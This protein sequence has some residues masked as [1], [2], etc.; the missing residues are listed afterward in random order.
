MID[1][2]SE[3]PVDEFIRVDRSTSK[4]A[5]SALA[6]EIRIDTLLS[7]MNQPDET[8]TFSELRKAVD[9]DD[10]GKFN[11]HLGK[12]V[13]HF[14][15]KT[16]DGYKLTH[17]GKEIVGAIYGGTYEADAT[18][19][20]LPLGDICITCGGSLYLEYAQ[21]AARIRCEDCDR[22]SDDYPFP[23]RGLDQ[24]SKAEL[25]DTIGKWIDHYIH[26]LLAG[27]CPYCTGRIESQ[28][29]VDEAERL[30][31]FPAH[32]EFTCMR[33]N[34]SHRTPATSP[35]DAHPS[36]RHFLQR[37]GLD[38]HTPVWR[39]FEVMG[40]PEVALLS[41]DPPRL[42]VRISYEEE[43]L[44]AVVDATAKVVQIGWDTVP[45]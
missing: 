33:C 38:V 32:A 34:I 39:I 1:S 26:G 8:Y 24:F 6:N 43:E 42:E 9:V 27:F 17:A 11:Y 7:M 35:V 37:H 15:R 12:L 28:L 40:R 2:T 41:K 10:P 44:H 16:D 18:V 21:E 29:C 31:G 3:P 22:R 14:I 45:E 19:E 30:A 4:E 25:R 20:Y 5:W 13:D 36:F 23:P